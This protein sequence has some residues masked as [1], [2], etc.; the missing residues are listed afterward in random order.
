LILSLRQKDVIFTFNWDPFLFD[1]RRRLEGVAPMPSIYYLHGNVRM[2]A[3]LDCGD[4]GPVEDCCSECGHAFS[5]SRLLFP[6]EKKNY[7]DDKFI[8]RQWSSVEKKLSEAWY[9]TIFGY[10]APKTDEEAMEIFANAWK[11]N[12]H[13]KSIERLEIIDVRDPEE[14]SSQWGEFAHFRHFDIRSSFF[15]STLAT[16]PRRT[17]EALGF[18]GLEGEFVQPIPWPGNLEGLKTSMADLASYERDE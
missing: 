3:C 6:V 10:S 5:P 12:G 7:A 16:Y 4:S 17:C 13:Q 2:G 11:A 15:E 14:L 1:A 9:V 8:R 18:M